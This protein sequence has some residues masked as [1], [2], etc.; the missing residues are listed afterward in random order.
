MARSSALTDADSSEDSL[1]KEECKMAPEVQAGRYAVAI[2]SLGEQHEVKE[3]YSSLK[4]ECYAKV[5]FMLRSGFR[6]Y[7]N[8]FSSKNYAY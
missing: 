1:S 7:P 4:D 3:N 6:S 8:D 2:H 5:S